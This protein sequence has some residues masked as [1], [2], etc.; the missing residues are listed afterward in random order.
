MLPC[1][2]LER[3]H[4]WCAASASAWAAAR[5]SFGSVTVG[6]GGPERAALVA[7]DL[8]AVPLSFVFLLMRNEVRRTVEASRITQGENLV[9]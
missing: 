8:A 7:V 1:V 5:S 2:A 4:N 3:G 6:L 9:G